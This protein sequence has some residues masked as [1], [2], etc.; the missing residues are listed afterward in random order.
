MKPVAE[1]VWIFRY[2]LGFLGARLGRTVSII[3]LRSGRLVTHSTG[4]FRTEDVAAISALGEPTWLVDVTTLHDSFAEQGRRA[5][6]SSTYLVPQGFPGAENL[7][8]QTLNSAPAE[9]EGELEL[10]KIGGIPKLQEHAMFHVPSR[11]LIVADLLF[12]IGATASSWTKFF[13]RRVMR[14]EKLVGMS[15]FFRLMI[16]DRRAFNHSI[17]DILQWDF[18][19]IIVGHGEIIRVGARERVSELL[20]NEGDRG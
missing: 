4:P 1:N 11:T 6:P 19:R 13:A 12:N 18:E 10:L 14:L 3:R 2:P 9:W 20:G 5:F 16:R 8:A 17:R 15:L 7:S